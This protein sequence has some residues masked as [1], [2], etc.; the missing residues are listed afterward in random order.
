MPE[1]ASITLPRFISSLAYFQR[2]M[3]GRAMDSNPA[4]VRAAAMASLVSSMP[5]G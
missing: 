1:A 2:M 5:P 3:S 4:P